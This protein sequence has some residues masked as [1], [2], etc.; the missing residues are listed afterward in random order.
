MRKSSNPWP[1]ALL[2]LARTSDDI[3]A[4]EHSIAAY[5]SAITLASLIGDDMLRRE[6]KYS[7]GLA[8][9]LLGNRGSNHAL[10]GAA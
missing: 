7:Y 4:L 9:N 1:D 6:L 3:N 5:R 10:T 8:R 2:T